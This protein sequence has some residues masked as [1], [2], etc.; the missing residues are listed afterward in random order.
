MEEQ[1][2]EDK[3]ER[4]KLWAEVQDV[5]KRLRRLEEKKEI[6]GMAEGKSE[7]EV[8][9]LEERLRKIERKEE[10]R[11]NE[12]KRSN[13]RAWQRRDEKGNGRKR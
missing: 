12:G 1:R 9:R 5:G 10:C 3:M 7:A 8:K 13:I 6:K 2:R 4:E 11:E